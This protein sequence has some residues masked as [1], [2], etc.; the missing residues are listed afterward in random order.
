M[1]K[2]EEKLLTFSI[3]AASAC[4]VLFAVAVYFSGIPFV[5]YMPVFIVLTGIVVSNAMQ[6]NRI[7]ELRSEKG[8]KKPNHKNAKGTRD[9]W[10]MGRKHFTL[11]EVFLF[12]LKKEGDSMFE[13]ECLKASKPMKKRLRKYGVR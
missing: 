8:A 12:D 9:W 2:K 11:F 5:F 10:L 7:D 6:L 3:N 13:M 1:Y 4:A